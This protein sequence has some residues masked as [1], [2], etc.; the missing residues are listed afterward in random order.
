VVAATAPLF[1]HAQ[2]C[3]SGPTVLPGQS[4][5]PKWFGTAGGTDWRP[6]LNDPRWAAATARRFGTYNTTSAST[7]SLDEALYRVL[8]HSGTLYVS[9]QMLVDPWVAVDDTIDYVYFGFDKGSAGNHAWALGVRPNRDV[10]ASPVAAPAASVPA[11]SPLPYDTNAG[12]FNDWYES[13]DGSVTGWDDVAN[14]HPGS[15]AAFLSDVATWRNAV[16]GTWAITFKVDINAL[17][18]TSAAGPLRLFIGTRRTHMDGTLVNFGSSTL[19]AD[20][21][22]VGYSALD[23]AITIIPKDRT[24]WTQFTPPGFGACSPGAYITPLLIGT[25]SGTSLTSSIQACAPS[26]PGSPPGC[27]V[28]PAGGIANTFEA[29][30]QNVPNTG[31]NHAVR[32]KFRIAEWGSTIANW[33]FA[34]WKNVDGIPDTI[35]TDDV[36]TLI[37]P[38]WS[39]SYDAVASQGTVSFTCTAPLG[40][41]C[42]QLSNA[43]GY[44]HQCM[45]VELASG[46]V[47][48]VQFTTSAVYR[49]MNFTGLSKNV[50]PATIS[51]KGLEKVTGKAMD[52]DVYLYVQRLNMPDHGEKPQWLKHTSM[53]DTRRYVEMPPRL[54]RP[55]VFT[56]KDARTGKSG[57]AGANAKNNAAAPNAAEAAAAAEKKPT[58]LLPRVFDVPTLTGEQ[59]LATAWPTYKVFPYYDTGRTTKVRGKTYKVVEPMVPFG[60]HMDHEG[61]LYGFTHELRGLEK[62]ALTKIADDYYKVHI[63]NEGSVRLETMLTAEEQPKKVVRETPPDACE[64]CKKTGGCA[65]ALGTSGQTGIPALVLVAAMALLGLVRVAARRRRERSP[66]A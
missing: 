53:A 13:P 51:I 60:F 9:V 61:P 25:L 64:K 28:C 56:P 29:R 58:G 54:P 15:K 14:K 63:P 21:D 35:F 4:G 34:G 19:A 17:G 45:L 6:E 40:G 47:A 46:P 52:R 65:C 55:I 12:T 31:I 22:T 38:P 5:P 44:K 18:I 7:G 49:N 24:T 59:A 42:P 3:I 26:C 27:V 48:G 23:G 36:S 37:N 11:D 41:Y 66:R 62:A 8:Y 33:Q 2:Q 43:D 32:A 57:K 10:A 39:W 50:S 20:A 30:V 16:G 1:A